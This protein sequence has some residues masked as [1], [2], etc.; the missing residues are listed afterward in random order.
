MQDYF[1]GSPRNKGL[2]LCCLTVKYVMDGEIA[3]FNQFRPRR[4]CNLKTTKRFGQRVC[5]KY[6]RHH[7]HDDWLLDDLNAIGIVKFQQMNGDQ[8]RRIARSRRPPRA[9]NPD[10]MNPDYFILDEAH[11]YAPI[12]A[13]A[14]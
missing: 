14:P 6:L 12:Y 4:T 2:G 9:F 10:Y 3:I 8:L 7:L 11:H 5:S 13:R 1:M